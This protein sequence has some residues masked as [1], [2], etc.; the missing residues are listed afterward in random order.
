MITA[1]LKLFFI[2]SGGGSF[3]CRCRCCSFRMCEISKL[4]WN[5]WTRS[6]NFRFITNKARRWVSVEMKIAIVVFMSSRSYSVAVPMGI[7]MRCDSHL[8][9]FL[10][11]KTAVDENILCVRFNFILFFSVCSLSHTP[12]HTHFSW[13][14]L[15]WQRIF[16]WAS[17]FIDKNSMLSTNFVLLLVDFIF[18]WMWWRRRRR[19]IAKKRVLSIYAWRMEKRFGRSEK[20]IGRKKDRQPRKSVKRNNIRIELDAGETQTNN[21]QSSYTTLKKSQ[22]KNR[23]RQKDPVRPQNQPLKRLFLSEWSTVYLVFICLFWWN[24]PIFWLI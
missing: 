8:L 13:D 3:F 4:W 9:R 15:N 11:N 21:L 23:N 14:T 1:L 19:L 17:F 6:S 10:R 2:L 5:E 12:R 16:V 18:I 22:K 24:S 20:K 7:S